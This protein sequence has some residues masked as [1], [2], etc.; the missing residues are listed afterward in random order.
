M[1][2][3]F[4]D[5]IPKWKP[6]VL[7]EAAP[8]PKDLSASIIQDLT[9]LGTVKDKKGNDVPVTQ[10]STGMTQL[11]GCTALYIISRKGVFAAHYWESVSFDPDKV[12]L[13]TGVKAWTPE[14]KAQMFKTTVLDPL[15]NRSK[16]H[17]KLKKKILEDEYIKAYLIIPNQTWREAGASD[18]GYEDQW[19]EMQNMVNSIIPTLGKEGRWTRIRYK[20]VTNPDDLGSRYKA[21]GKNIFK[22]DSRHPDPDSKTGGTQHKAALW[23]E[24]ETIPYHNETW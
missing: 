22:Y 20:L 12:W 8:K 3:F 11:K 6:F 5:E 24:D 23:V 17:P 7:R 9:N 10:F 21:N 16:Y 18:T 1:P 4:D 15:R 2:D 19:T 13:T 14:A